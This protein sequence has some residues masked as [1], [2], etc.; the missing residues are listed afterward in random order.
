VLTVIIVAV[1]AVVVIVIVVAV[2]AREGFQMVLRV[3]RPFVLSSSENSLSSLKSLI[4]GI[5]QA[6]DEDDVAEKEPKD[7]EMIEF[8]R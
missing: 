6:D 3:N 5:G 1:D 2:V 4:F 7:D 8:R